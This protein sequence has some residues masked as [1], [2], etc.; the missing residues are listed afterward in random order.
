MRRAALTAVWSAGRTNTA[1]ALR[2]LRETMFTTQ[3]G[4]RAGVQNIAILLTDGNSNNR[5]ETLKEATAAKVAG[6]H[7]IVTGIGN[8]D[9]LS[10]DELRGIAS[11]PDKDNMYTV[12]TFQE[13]NNLRPAFKKSICNGM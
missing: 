1:A 11:D 12:R 6:I 7:L 4:D 8:P 5:R 13:I 2:A 10:L 3:N 9:W